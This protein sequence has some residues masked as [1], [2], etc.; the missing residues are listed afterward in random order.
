MVATV[1]V[2]MG[3][4]VGDL[5]DLLGV[6]R[7]WPDVFNA[8]ADIHRA[9]VDEAEKQATRKRQKDMIA[10]ARAKFG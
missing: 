3:Q 1:A 2:S 8:M 7:C 6:E 5:L 9:R 4:P 10:K